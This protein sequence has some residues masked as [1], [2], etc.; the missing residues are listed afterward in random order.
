MLGVSHRNHCFI[1][2]TE[3]NE[4]SKIK[5]EKLQQLFGLKAS[6]PV[7]RCFVEREGFFFIRHGVTRC[8][9]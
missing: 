3:E 2:D 4:S 9:T 1:G 7:L 8:G 5:K 6:Q